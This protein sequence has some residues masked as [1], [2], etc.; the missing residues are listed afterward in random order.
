MKRR[1]LIAVLSA[2]MLLAGLSAALAVHPNV[3]LKDAAGNDIGNS[4]TPYSPK[5]TCAR[6]CHPAETGLAADYQHNYGS[7]E[8]HTIHTQG[9]LESDGNIY[10][11]SY[12]VK[13]FEH[14]ASVGR[15]VNQGRNENYS[16]TFR[17][18]YGLP[19]FTSSPGMAGKF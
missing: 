14:G 13:S 16:N 8:K 19:W 5:S 15:H 18:V 11:Q 7:G 12:D 10:W 9:V 4:T 17:S 6:V 1:L 2:I 3:P